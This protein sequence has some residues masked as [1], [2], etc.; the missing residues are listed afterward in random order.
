M[1]LTPLF[2]RAAFGPGSGNSGDQVRRGQV[3]RFKKGVFVRLE[4]VANALLR[5]NKLELGEV[6]A[7]SGGVTGEQWSVW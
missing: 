1:T 7:V 2:A 4:V 5:R 6:A 3:L